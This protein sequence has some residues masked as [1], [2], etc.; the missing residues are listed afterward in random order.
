MTEPSCLATI[1]VDVRKKRS[2]TN[3]CVFV[4]ITKSATY[5][6]TNH[7]RSQGRE[8]PL[9]LCRNATPWLVSPA[10]ISPSAEEGAEEEPTER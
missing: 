6:L 7:T 9:R 5:V 4:P 10:R 1:G 2:Q 3:D 8:G